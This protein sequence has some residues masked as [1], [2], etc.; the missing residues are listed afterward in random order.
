MLENIGSIRDAKLI[1][2]IALQCSE[3]EVLFGELF[4]KL[5]RGTER[6]RKMASWTLS[7][8]I[9]YNPSC[10]R[11]GQH[12][13]LLEFLKTENSGTV[14]RNIIRAW[15]FAQPHSEELQGRVVEYSLE[16]FFD[17]K[18]ETA[19]RAFSITVLEKY[20]LLFPE[21]AQEVVFQL[22]KELPQAGA[23]FTVRGRK[24]LKQFQKLFPLNQ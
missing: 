22:E 14:V 2:A 16:K 17:T 12:T 3:N 10:I 4:H 8:A 13:E 7:T 5:I 18:N 9:E 15:Q 23:A 24:Y 11:D 19:I 21:L 1:K 20:I 6:E